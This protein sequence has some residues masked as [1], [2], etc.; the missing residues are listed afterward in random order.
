MYPP[1]ACGVPCASKTLF[2]DF[3]YHSRN[4]DSS[5]L[6]QQDNIC[7]HDALQN[8]QFTGW[9]KCQ[10][11]LFKHVQDIMSQR[12]ICSVSLQESLL[13]Y[14]TKCKSQNNISM[15][16]TFHLFDYMQCEST[17]LCYGPV[18]IYSELIWGLSTVGRSLILAPVHILI[19]LCDH[20]L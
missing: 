9:H 20:L 3:Y 6:F 2:N 18:K 19:S 5:L 8:G 15:D 13:P 16:G 17:T 14:A 11:F 7:L 12:L 10:T 1:T 4:R